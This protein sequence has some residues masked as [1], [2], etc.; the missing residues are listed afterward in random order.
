[1]F[2][3]GEIS[4]HYNDSMNNETCNKCGRPMA[5]CTEGN[6]GRPTCQCQ[7]NSCCGSVQQKTTASCPDGAVIPSITVDRMDQ[8]KGIY[9]SFVHV[10]ENNNTLYID[11]NG[12]VIITWAGPINVPDYDMAGNPN[13]YRD[14]IV[15]DTDK[16]RAA[17]Y[18]KSGI[19]Y[20]FA[21]VDDT[22][23]K[24]AVEKKINEMIE[25]GTFQELID[26]YLAVL[27][28]TYII[29]EIT[30]EKG[31]LDGTE[32]YIA[33]I[34]RLDSDGN[35]IEL[36]HGFADD[37]N[38]AQATDTETPR[39]FACR[40]GATFCSNASPF[41]IDSS[42]PSYHHVMGCIIKDGQL[43]SNYPADGYT[44]STKNRLRM[45][46]IKQDGTFIRYPFDTTYQT[47]QA[48]GIWNSFCTF[49]QIM[50][51]GVI[52]SPFA[53]TKDI[54]NIICQNSTTK[55]IMFICCNGRNIQEQAGLSHN[56]LLNIAISKGYDTA[57]QLD[58]GGSA[59]FIQQG[60]MM[61]EPYD[62]QGR[63]VRPTVDYI[64]FGKTPT[65]N[66]DLNF[67]RVTSDASEADIKAKIERNRVSY[68]QHIENNYLDFR[69]PN[70]RHSAEQTE[71][72]GVHIRYYKNDVLDKQLI[73]GAE[74][75]P[76]TLALYDNITEHSLIKLNA[77]DSTL[78][79]GGQ[80][81]A[82]FFRSAQ[83]I[84]DYDDKTES[85]IWRVP[86]NAAHKPWS[87]T[88]GGICIN[89]AGVSGGTFQ[90]AIPQTTQLGTIP[91]CIR[92][93]NGTS[94]TGWF[95]FALPQAI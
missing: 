49:G 47:M 51:N 27:K 5:Y 4:L 74:S 25:D 72:S 75:A 37:V 52:S 57:F 23:V 9:G 81:F 84:T 65:T 95:K 54:W 83:N 18:D 43:I 28:Q 10:A 50:E 87:S 38:T 60:I 92:S 17:I 26:E 59:G 69:Y 85:G 70:L 19:G 20:M 68:L 76:N 89:L 29:N 94:W 66:V 78:S 90:I 11:E 3:G 2:F 73:F 48:D 64:Y 13:N 61:N 44:Q 33:Y 32:Y 15:T 30:F 71:N 8:I 14:Q 63:V 56:Q 34:P 77:D 93:W 1:M 12:R 55:D 31:V 86:G 21:L 36:Q 91:I 6:C 16:K 45:L 42:L 79:I 82:T 88:T 58:A 53:E 39:E 80:V 7:K 67:M 22:S 35:V 40:K 62:S 41:A 24:E 46:G